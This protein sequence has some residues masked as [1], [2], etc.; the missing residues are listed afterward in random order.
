MSDPNLI[1]VR[2]MI[3]LSVFVL[4][5]SDFSKLAILLAVRF[6]FGQDLG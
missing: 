2:S 3:W 6:S 5:E 1:L 4:S